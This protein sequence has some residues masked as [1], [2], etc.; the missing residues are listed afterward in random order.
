MKFVV[1]ALG[2]AAGGGKELAL[3]LVSR[4]QR[5]EN[6]EFVCVVPDLPEYTTFRGKNLKLIVWSKPN[7]LP[8]RFL[9]LHRTLPRICT[10]ERADALLCLGNFTPWDPPCPTVVMLQN[11]FIVRREP[12]VERRLSLRERLII[13]YGRIVYRRLSPQVRVVVQTETMR[14][15]LLSQFKVDPGKVDI[16]GNSISLPQNRV[17]NS[18]SRAADPSRPFTFVCLTRYYPHKNL[19]ILLEAMKRLPAHS[20]RAARCVITISADQHPGAQKLLQRIAREQLGHLFVNLGPVPRSRLQEVY[21]SADALILPTLLESF[22]RTYLEAMHFGLPI[23]ISDRDFAR[24]ACEDAALY[25]DPLDAEDVAK[26]MAKVMEDAELRL[27]LISNGTRLIKRI[28][29]WEEIAGQFVA[30]LEN[31]GKGFPAGSASRAKLAAPLRRD[32]VRWPDDS[33]GSG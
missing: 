1:E 12:I 32:E 3:N 4:F 16:I 18:R 24:A 13:A 22:S 27:Q 23:L 19:E 26:S 25:F 7:H 29:T 20:S 15:R 30:A 33:R 6:H 21:G 31:A 9:F 14:Q 8:V 28:P 10:Q 5:Y 17:G 2:L 11:A